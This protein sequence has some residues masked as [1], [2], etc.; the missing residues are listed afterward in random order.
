[1]RMRTAVSITAT[2]VGALALVGPTGPLGRSPS[3]AGATPSTVAVRVWADAGGPPINQ[4]LIGVDGPGPDGAQ[5]A[6]AAIG[7]RTIR[8]DASLEGSLNGTPVYD[9][10]TGTWDPALLD[11]RVAAAEQEGGSPEII[12]DY[13]PPCLA[14]PIL[15][16]Q[17][18]NYAQPDT[19]G[20][21]AAWDALVYQMA[22]HEITA[23]G[24]R[25]FEIWNEPDGTFWL[26]G[27]SGY[28]TLYQDTAAVLEKAASAAHV[29]IEVGGPALFYVDPLWVTPFLSF[30]AT[31]H[32]P[33]DFFSWHYYAN[34]PEIGP[35]GPIP[36][37]PPGFPPIWYNSNLDARVYGQQVAEVRAALAWF[38]TLHPLLWI[39]EWNVDAGYD[40]R[41]E[42]PYDAAFAA[43]VLDSVQGSGLG[44]MDF[45]DVAD[46]PTDPRADWGLLD[47]DLAVKPVYETFEYWHEMARHQVP[48]ALSPDQS[49]QDWFGRVGAVAASGPDHRVTV[50]LYNFLTYSLTDD[51]GT[52]DP[53]SFDHEIDLR[54][55][56]LG[57]RTYTWTQ[58]TTD[59]SYPSGSVTAS[60]TVRGPG[61]TLRFTLAGEGVTLLTFSPTA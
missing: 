25:I 57:S 32:L 24:V 31:N 12:V 15:S 43:A 18:P 14:A 45:F 37:P 19:D 16:G 38:P 34:Y 5:P 7:V 4:D 48:T 23:E 3:A 59:A 44:R 6:M 2:V 54:V 46:S 10:T 17:N 35:I 41:M 27:L 39:D 42:G 58:D 47:A 29:H 1:M 11:S 56:G 53:T 28:E 9:C 60:G 8:L 21:Q 61:A 26:G 49:G 52:T 33:L 30:V 13:T 51:Y 40:A 22:F 36:M 50:L 20:H 55:L